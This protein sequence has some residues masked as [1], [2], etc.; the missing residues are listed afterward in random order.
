ME[1]EIVEREEVLRV[2]AEQVA[3]EMAEARKAEKSV[4]DLFDRIGA[5]VLGAQVWVGI[6]TKGNEGMKEALEAAENDLAELWELFGKTE[7]ALGRL[8]VSISRELLDDSHYDP[9]N[10]DEN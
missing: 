4:R 10:S 5:R 9:E 8:R 1:G 6:A 3:G 2:L 7:K